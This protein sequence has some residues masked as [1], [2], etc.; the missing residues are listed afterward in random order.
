MLHIFSVESNEQVNQ[1][2][3]LSILL[4]ELFLY[5]LIS[6]QSSIY[7]YRF[8]IKP[9]T[10]TPTTH[11]PELQSVSLKPIHFYILI[12]IRLLEQKY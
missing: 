10:L 11:F 12:S 2:Q 1:K 9:F 3:N 8:L 7:Y 5:R 4:I 6:R